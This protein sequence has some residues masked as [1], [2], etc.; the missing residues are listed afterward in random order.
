MRFFRPWPDFRPGVETFFFG[1]VRPFRTSWLMLGMRRE[2]LAAGLGCGYCHFM[3]SA[4]EK[5]F[6]EGVQPFLEEGEE[7]LASSIAQAKGFSRMMVS[8]LQ[9]G[10]SQV[11]GSTAAAESGE[12]RVDNPMAIVL[13]NRRLLT[14]KISA[15]IGLGMGGNVKELMTAIPLT[16]VDS[17]EVKKIALRQNITLIVRGVE[18]PLE[19]NAKAN[20]R[21]LADEF[22]RMK[23][24]A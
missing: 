16:E 1:L 15:P 10:Q 8:G 9:L 17:I 14:V 19:T 5:K 24:A 2:R 22:A 21:G 18:I 3:A 13:T 12:V 11:A 20:A 23:A 4:H 6:T 7:V